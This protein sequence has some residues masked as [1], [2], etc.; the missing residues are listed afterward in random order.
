MYEE[1]GM[2]F[3]GDSCVQHCFMC[4]T[5]LRPD[6]FSDNY[7]KLIKWVVIYGGMHSIREHTLEPYQRNKLVR[8][9]LAEGFEVQ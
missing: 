3:G 9:V 8:K 6:K 2:A 1:D 4:R 7:F 5:A